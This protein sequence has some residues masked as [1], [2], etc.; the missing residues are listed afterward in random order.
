M[1]MQFESPRMARQKIELTTT[2]KYNE[3]IRRIA[4]FEVNEMKRATRFSENVE[5]PD[6]NKME[7]YLATL[8]WLRVCWVRDEVPAEYRAGYRRYR[9]PA[10]WFTFL[11]NI[12]EAKDFGRNFKFIP[13][14]NSEGLGEVLKPGKGSAPAAVRFLSHEELL[15]V[16]DMME[17]LYSEG[18][19]TVTGLPKEKQGSLELMAKTTIQ[20]TIM[21]MDVHNPVYAFLAFVL[22]V[23]VA[24]D[25]NDN[26]ELLFRTEYS[27]YDVYSTGFSNY[28]TQVLGGIDGMPQQNQQP[29]QTASSGSMNDG[30][31]PAQPAPGSP[32]PNL[33][34]NGNG[35]TNSN[36]NL[37][38]NDA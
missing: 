19:P 31:G 20:D 37:R 33:G 4:K 7:S 15:N 35:A 16:T 26:V 14:F 23:D 9:V 24:A 10:R 6:D 34:H 25:S 8:L 1:S 12:G 32:P 2:F 17:Y 11:V 18:Y 29:S 13:A 28:Y 5:I 30:K 36:G 22:E 38:G 3:T 27:S 21:G